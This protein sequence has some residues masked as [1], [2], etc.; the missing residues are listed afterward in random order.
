MCQ[1]NKNE[2]L[3]SESKSIQVYISD[4]NSAR[5]GPILLIFFKRSFHFSTFVCDDKI[6]K[7]NENLKRKPMRNL[8]FEKSTYT[9]IHPLSAFA[10]YRLTLNLHF[11]S[12][13][14]LP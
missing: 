11:C 12:I 5:R 13:S 3:Y 9:T 1:T 14:L 8:K 10:I 7:V 2:K 6:R 4:C